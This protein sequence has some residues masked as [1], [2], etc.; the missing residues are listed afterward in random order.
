MEDLGVAWEQLKKFEE[1]NNAIASELFHVSRELA[2]QKLLLYAHY[3][4][5]RLLS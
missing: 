2:Q 4:A 1:M 5:T 3:Y